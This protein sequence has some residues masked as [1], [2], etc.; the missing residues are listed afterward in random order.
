LFGDAG[1]VA[2]GTAVTSSDGSYELSQAEAAEYQLEVSASGFE[3]ETLVVRLKPGERKLIDIGLEL[4]R[5]SD[6]PEIPLAGTVSDFAGAPLHDATVTA[7]AAFNRRFVYSTR[8]RSDG[9]FGLS[10]REGGQYIVI[11]YDLKR[12]VAAKAVVAMP[13]VGSIE[14]RL[15]ALP[16]P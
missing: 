15:A 3:R 2:V 8:T 7:T 5:T 12:A 6:I 1:G 9:T 14:L 10:I 16:Q 13:G 11:A 4:G